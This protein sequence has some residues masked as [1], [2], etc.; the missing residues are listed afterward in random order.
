MY[1]L[2][3]YF[4]QVGRVAVTDLDVYPNN[5]MNFY[6]N[7]IC[8]YAT[9]SIDFLLILNSNTGVFTLKYDVDAENVVASLDAMVIVIDP[10]VDNRF[11]NTIFY[12]L[13]QVY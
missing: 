8:S 4:Q 13:I 2:Y 7:T 6:L 10:T 3:Y 5:Q 11:V 1:I 9:S 12:I